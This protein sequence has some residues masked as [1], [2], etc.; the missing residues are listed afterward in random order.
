M[1]ITWGVYSRLFFLL[2]V[3]IGSKLNKAIFLYTGALAT[4][5]VM[6]PWLTDLSY[7]EAQV[8]GYC[9]S[10]CAFWWL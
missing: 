8:L 3:L 6:S 1:V 4:R 5:N 7:N 10:L 2:E 9:L